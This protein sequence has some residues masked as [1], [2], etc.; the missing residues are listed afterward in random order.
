MDH[1]CGPKVTISPCFNKNVTPTETS[2]SSAVSEDYAGLGG[3]S[4]RLSPL[5]GEQRE[6]TSDGRSDASDAGCAGLGGGCVDVSGKEEERGSQPPI[7][8]RTGERA[9][10]WKDWRAQ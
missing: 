1:N 10:F 9:D 7:S 4:I 6:T 3:G 2:T 5:R 8:G